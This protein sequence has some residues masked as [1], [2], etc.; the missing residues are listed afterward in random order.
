MSKWFVISV[1]SGLL[2]IVLILLQTRGASLGAGLGGGGEVNTVR[3]GSEASIFK[4]TIILAVIF[5]FCILAGI[6]T[7]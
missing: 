7:S 1:V 6:V 5:V 3:R 2:M 4:L